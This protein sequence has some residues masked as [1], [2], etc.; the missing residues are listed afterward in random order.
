[1]MDAARRCPNLLGLGDL[2]THARLGLTA[3]RPSGTS[4]G[5]FL[6]LAVLE[7]ALN[8]AVAINQF[9]A[10]SSDFVDN[11]VVHS[12]S[13]AHRLAEAHLRDCL[14]RN[15]QRSTQAQPLANRIQPFL[16]DRV[17]QMGIIPR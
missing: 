8:S 17:R 2:A 12:G 13:P 1:A 11:R 6:S 9:L 7:I 16:R 10:D 4:L 14:G 3:A 15:Q 5:L